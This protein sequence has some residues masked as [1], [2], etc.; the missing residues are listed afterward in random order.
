MK[1]FVAVGDNHG[2][3]IHRADC[4]SFISFIKDYR[5]QIRVHLGDNWD[6]RNLRRGADPREEGDDIEPDLTAG[7]MF[8]EKFQPTHFL[9]GNHDHRLWKACEDSRGL[10]RQFA[11]DGVKHIT[12]T[13]TK[14]GAEILPY[15]YRRGVLRIGQLGFLHGYHAGENAT[16]Q[17]ATVYGSCLFGHLHT[18]DVA[19]ARRLEKAEARCVGCLADYE[20]MTYADQ[21]TATLRWAR[22]WAFGII[23]EK[24]GSYLV[25]QA[26][27]IDNKW[28]IPTGI[29]ES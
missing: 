9:A 24:T 10:V 17:H 6:F 25:W 29:K 5:P 13:L 11:R 26:E 16:K 18:I 22:G 28:L 14:M 3:L 2:D 21:R 1:R 12:E 20:R 19:R 8:L 23:N 7:F 4:D 27:K 15:H